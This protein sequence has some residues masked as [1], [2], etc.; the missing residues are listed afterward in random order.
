MGASGAGKSSLLDVLST[1]APQSCVKGTY[2]LNGAPVTSAFRRLSG[3]VMQDDVVYPKL[4]V[5]ETLQ[6]RLTTVLLS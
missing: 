5:R 3:Y 6:V 4:T 2:L 1:R